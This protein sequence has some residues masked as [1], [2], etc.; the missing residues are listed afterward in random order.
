[1]RNMGEVGLKEIARALL[2]KGH[3]PKWLKEV[4][5]RFSYPE[6]VIIPNLKDVPSVTSQGW[7]LISDLSN[8]YHSAEYWMLEKAIANLM[9]GKL[10]YHLCKIKMFGILLFRK[11]GVEIKDEPET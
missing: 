8:P 10:T 6:A 1:M 7:N 11:G 9:N 2:M 5:G 4:A 3:C